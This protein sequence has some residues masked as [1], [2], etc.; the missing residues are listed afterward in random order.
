MVLPSSSDT[1]KQT[2]T[3]P[4]LAIKA[5]F[6]LIGLGLIISCYL[7]YR[8]LILAGTPGAS[9]PD[10]CSAVFGKGCDNALD[11]STAYQLGIPLAGWGI[12]YY[13]VL[14]ML[15][16]L[17]FILKD[18]VYKRVALVASVLSLL[19][20]IGSVILLVFFALNPSLFCPFCAIIHTIN[21]IL[22]FCMLPVARNSLISLRE[23]RL[24]STATANSTAIKT[25]LAAFAAVVVV[26]VLMYTG[27]WAFAGEATLKNRPF[28]VQFFLSG[29]NKLPK[30]AVSIDADDPVFGP[31]DSPLEIIVF[32]DF[33][34]SSCRYFSL[35][36]AELNKKYYNKF[37]VAFKN[38]PLGKS[39]NPVV[40]DEEVHAH[41]CEAA[42]A[43]E[44]AKK[45]GRFWEFHDALFATNLNGLDSNV[46]TIADKTGLDHT[47]FEQHRVSKTAR[48]KIEKSIQ[49]GIAL[50][51][52]GTPA[53]YLN[54]REVKD[55]RYMQMQYL[56]DHLLKQNK[57]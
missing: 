29:Y 19:G 41:A 49:Q 52:S 43:A 5:G 22:V 20:S 39:C 54:K 7:L 13:A 36:L 32:S 23:E 53:V 15:L 57:Q 12:I 2:K 47:L 1:S 45:Q 42:L 17:P 14:L 26:A 50:G 31:V 16:L 28:D 44:A 37:H 30:T 24:S 35:V 48:M 34:C 25:K 33:Q 9:Q 56:F 11:S 21:I 51:I 55:F 8:H 18:Q 27:L 3:S 10:V 40:G 6:L 4:G 38:F 46:C